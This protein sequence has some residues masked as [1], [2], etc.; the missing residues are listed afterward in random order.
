[1]VTDL[2]DRARIDA[3]DIP[4]NPLHDQHFPSIDC[5][6]W[7]RAI[8]A[9]EDVRAGDDAGADQSM[10]AMLDGQAQA[11]GE[12]YLV[13]AGP[14]DAELLTLKGLRLLQ[15][16]DVVL[17]DALV[18]QDVIDLARRDAVLEDVGKRRGHC[19]MPQGA[20][21]DR[22]IEWAR[23]G[24]RVCRLKSGDPYLFGRGGE[25]ALALVEAQIP[26]QTVPGISSAAGISAQAGIPLT[27]RGIARSVRFVTGHL[28]G[29]SLPADWQRLVDQQETSVLYMA[30]HHLPAI[31]ASL[32][33]AGV[34]A[35]MPVALIQNGA[36]ANQQVWVT[37]VDQCTE[38]SAAID[39]E[40]GP[41]LVMVGQ[42]VSLREQLGV[43][44]NLADA[45]AR[46]WMLN[47]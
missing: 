33:A 10:Q 27:H 12:V 8:S 24:K 44:T 7:T 46:S 14:G 40:R 11:A 35:D 45:T 47:A 31:Q 32:L 2:I 41:T 38:A 30:L 15:Q 28:A 19:P 43:G 9:G 20:I 39:P 26:F 17:Y 25:E 21:T 16:A 4:I 23:Q 29:G 6:P 37:Q 42:V 36:R 13:G 3:L 1:M 22:I 5:A 18:S 34:A